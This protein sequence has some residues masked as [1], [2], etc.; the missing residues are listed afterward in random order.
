V[1]D[2]VRIGGVPDADPLAAAQTTKAVAA[3]LRDARSLLR[4]TDKLAQAADAVADPETTR[5]AA[6][7]R[8]AIEQLVHR[9]G[10]LERQRQ[11][12]ARPAAWRGR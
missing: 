12:Q 6:Q 10:Q 1:G 3:L 4:R 9:V 8:Q 5:L 11:R 2:G 7:A